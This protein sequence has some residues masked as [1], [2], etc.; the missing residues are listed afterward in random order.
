MTASGRTSRNALSEGGLF[1]VDAAD[2]LLALVILQVEAKLSTV[3]GVVVDASEQGDST[4][5]ARE[6]QGGADQAAE[7]TA[8]EES[9]SRGHDASEL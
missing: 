1:L 2:S 8:A 4:E 5:A 6:Q 9:L 3:K 7:A